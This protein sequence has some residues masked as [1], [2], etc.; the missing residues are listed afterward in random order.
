MAKRQMKTL[1]PMHPGE[2]L[3]EEFLDPLRLTPYAVAKACGIPRN[4]IERIAREQISISADTALRFARFF[5]TSAQFWLN[6]QNRHDLLTAARRIARA[7]RSI[8]PFK[9]T[10]A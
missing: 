2:M 8:K 7:L 1:R 3:R 4:R 6:L 5:G 10:A 9:Q